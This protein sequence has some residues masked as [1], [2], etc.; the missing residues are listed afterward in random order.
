MKIRKRKL[1][2][3]LKW[4]LL[5]GVIC[6]I[7]SGIVCGLFFPDGLTRAVLTFNG[8]FGNFLGFMIPLLIVGLVA[9]GI[10]ELGRSAGKLLFITA[11][12]AYAFTLVSGFFSFT[13]ADL[14]LPYLLDPSSLKTQFASAV[15]LKPYF[16]IAM[17]P[18]MD[19][20][21]ALVFAFALGLGMASIQ[22]ERLKGIMV[23]FRNNSR[24]SKLQH[25]HNGRNQK[26]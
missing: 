11:A 26:D 15:E 2:L 7:I 10:A 17:P 18:L 5:P 6:A 8:L 4:G 23:D 9:P 24:Q 16:T 25:Q 19:V 14:A 22:G 3:K 20:M 1:H 21:S 13:V 12:L